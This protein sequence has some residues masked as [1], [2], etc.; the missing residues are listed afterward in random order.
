MLAIY[1]LGLGIPFILTALSV[2]KMMTAINKI[3]K[4]YNIISIISGILVIII[5]I[6]IFTDNLTRLSG[7]L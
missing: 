4:Y 2:N 1:S 3:K 7:F 6:L 5:G